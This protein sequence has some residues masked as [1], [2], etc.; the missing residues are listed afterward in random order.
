MVSEFYPNRAAFF[1]LNV[2]SAQR[3]LGMDPGW[4]PQTLLPDDV[5]GVGKPA[6]E[7]VSWF[8]LDA[9]ALA[10]SSRMFTARTFLTD[11]PHVSLFLLTGV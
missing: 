6:A 3:W 2:V 11:L 9:A 7:A 1:F 8:P 10:S 4:G 5:C